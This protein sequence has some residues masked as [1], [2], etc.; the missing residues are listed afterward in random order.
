MKILRETEREEEKEMK[1]TET[2][3]INLIQVSKEKYCGGKKKKIMR[4]RKEL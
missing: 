4:E 3:R 2:K 1:K